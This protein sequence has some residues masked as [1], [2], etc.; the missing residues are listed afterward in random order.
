MSDLP[1]GWALTTLGDVG[2]LFCGQSPSSSTVNEVGEGT[3]YVTGPEQWDGHRIHES[4][5]TTDPKRVVPNGC[6]FVTV[7]GSGVGTLFGG[8]AC[9]IG[10][11]VYAY[12]PSEAIEHDYALAGLQHTI[13]ELKAQAR[14]TIP[15]L[16]KSHIQ[17]HSI[18]LPPLAEQGRIVEKLDALSAQSTAAATALTQIETLIPRYKAAVLATELFRPAATLD[19]SAREPWCAALEAE[20]DAFKRSLR[21]SRLE[22]DAGLKFDDLPNGA[23]NWGKVYL[24]QVIG[25]ASGFAFKSA[26]YADEGRRL[27]RGANIAPGRID[28]TDVKYLPEL[29]AGDYTELELAAGDIVLAMDRPLI[30]TG[31]KIALVDEASAGCLLVQRVARIRHT[32]YARADYVWYLLNSEIFLRHAMGR[33]TGTDLPHI[34]SNDIQTTPICLPPL[35]EQAEIVAR[36]EAAFAEIETLARAAAAARA[37]LAQLDR[38]ILSRAFKGQLVPQNPDDE[39]ASELLKR[40]KESR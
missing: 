27:L 26:W 6:I 38:A 36:I 5:W 39:P 30:S 18:P 40:V 22:S 20:R 24:G 9:A 23:A 1:E 19:H 29:M 15:G 28:W 31:L 7:K 3:L 21:G 12:E 34:S 11:D 16:S 10:R 2:T 14:G 35:E 8:I 4:K 32:K 13:L 17:D 33:A 37:R 25:F